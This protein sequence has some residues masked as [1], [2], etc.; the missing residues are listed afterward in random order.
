MVEYTI[1]ISYLCAKLNIIYRQHG[2]G[3]APADKKRI[4]DMSSSLK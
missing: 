1:N 4:N 2:T 3:R